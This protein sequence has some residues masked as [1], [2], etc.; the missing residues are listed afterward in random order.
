MPTIT[1][2][3]GA[4]RVRTFK[5]KPK[6]TKPTTKKKTTKKKPSIR[7]VSKMQRL[8]RMKILT[9]EEHKKAPTKAE[10]ARRAA[11]AKFAIEKRE[12]EKKIE[13]QARKAAKFEKPLHAAVVP[14]AKTTLTAAQ[15]AKAA[16]E[17]TEQRVSSRIPTLG[18]ISQAGGTFA[19][20]HPE[21]AKKIL[22]GFERAHLKT[23]Q[24]GTDTQ[25][26]A[27]AG[28]TYG[29]YQSL[30]KKPVKT[31]A[32]FGAGLAG[33]KAISVIGKVGKAFGA[34]AKSA[35]MAKAA[36]LGILGIYG[37][38]TTKHIM[39]AP[40]AYK[41]GQRASEAM[42]TEILPMGIGAGVAARPG[43]KQPKIK[44][45]KPTPKAVKKAKVEVKYRA[46]K[47]ARP[48]K[49]PVTAK[50][51]AIK[52]KLVEKK[53]IVKVKQL[54]TK[55][56]ARTQIKTIDQKIN[57]LGKQLDKLKKDERGEVELIRTKQKEIEKIKSPAELQK[58]ISKEKANIRN[59]ERTFE[60][61]KDLAVKGRIR[62]AQKKLR[63]LETEKIQREAVRDEMLKLKQ[64]VRSSRQKIK[65][66]NKIIESEK[67]IL[68][69][70]KERLKVLIKEVEPIKPE[71]EKEIEALTER[72][73]VKE[74][75]K[76]KQIEREIEKVSVRERLK[77]KEVEKVKE[78]EIEKVSVRETEKAKQKERQK[79]KVKEKV[80]IMPEIP[81]LRVLK[82]KKTGKITRKV[83][84]EYT[85]F[86]I[87]NQMAGI[88]QLFG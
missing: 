83:T 57:K 86:Q 11:E 70:T 54:K 87:V 55:T 3:A 69:T 45:V 40:T 17:R 74:L 5:D 51:A 19:K 4:K 23:Q 82:K 41:A 88:N 43:I 28:Y 58:G 63:Q 49:K 8:E 56:A 10:R 18:R 13:A 36:E 20:K 79:T 16:Y 2:T 48:I 27:L 30:Q 33:G 75:E 38:Q 77:V 73:M 35:K 47:A 31:S 64:K 80:L 61:T 26:Q 46:K 6:T 42:Y 60:R 29:S 32:M 71:K 39:D 37:V 66:T 9:T 67:V 78:R 12:F 21:T 53:R 85:N 15:K 22:T 24:Y 72:Q 34:G 65:E 7:K 44:K 14:A 52:R 76:V 59:L 1:G 25:R 50:K 84:K 62:I 68:R 81:K